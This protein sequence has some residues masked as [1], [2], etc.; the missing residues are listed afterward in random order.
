MITNKNIETIFSDCS[1]LGYDVN[2]KDIAYCL[3]VDKF[4]DP[5]LAYV[6]VFG[7]SLEDAKIKI[8]AYNSLGK[9]TFLKAH[10][11]L[12]T[13]DED[14]KKETKKQT[15]ITYDENLVYFLKI[16]SDIE[17][18]MATGEI[19]ALGGNKALADIS[20]K[21]NDKFKI[22]DDNK[23]QVVVVET[24]YNDVCSY[25][26]HEVARAPITKEE[27]MKMYNLVEK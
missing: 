11:S 24:K 5:S 19:D 25:C 8:V 21:L 2:Y 6:C 3:I 22:N 10:L 1:D 13:K 15:N 27:A 7:G 20:V 16:R 9:I 17:E 18:K 4:E 14:K 23:G 12:Y 26:Q